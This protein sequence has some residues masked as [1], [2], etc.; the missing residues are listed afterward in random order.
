[1]STLGALG[2][3]KTITSFQNNKLLNKLNF[4][5]LSAACELYASEGT[6]TRRQNK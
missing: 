4:R 2:E 5:R 1:M 3:V 6:T